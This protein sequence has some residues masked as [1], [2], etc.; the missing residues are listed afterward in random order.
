MLVTPP[1]LIKDLGLVDNR[2]MDELKKSMPILG[3]SM[4]EWVSENFLK[5]FGCARNDVEGKYV[6]WG[7]IRSSH[8]NFSEKTSP[9]SEILGKGYESSLDAIVILL[10]LRIKMC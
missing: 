7:S 5:K 10:F 3:L 1:L 4:D 8:S 6:F 9:I 2:P